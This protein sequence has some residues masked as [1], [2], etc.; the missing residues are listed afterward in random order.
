L[1]TNSLRYSGA[2]NI[3]VQLVQD[4]KYV[5]LTVQDDGCGFDEKEIKPGI[6]LKNIRDRVAS[7]NGKLDIASSTGNG[8]ETTIELK[9]ES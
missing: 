5:S 4:E 3:N 9:V 1:I 6:G 8:T 7:Y 2:E